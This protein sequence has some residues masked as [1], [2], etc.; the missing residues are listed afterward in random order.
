[1]TCCCCCRALPCAQEMRDMVKEFMSAAE[2]DLKYFEASVGNVWG[3]R[4]GAKGVTQMS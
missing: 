1:M 2:G 4:G 3:M